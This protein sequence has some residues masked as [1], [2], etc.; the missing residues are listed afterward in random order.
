VRLVI[1]TLRETKLWRL[2]CACIAHWSIHGLVVAALARCVGGAGVGAEWIF[3]G[4]P[5]DE[6]E[7]IL[8]VFGAD[9]HDVL[10]GDVSRPVTFD[11]AKI[12]HERVAVSRE[13][14]ERPLR[15]I[16]INRARQ[17][18]GPI[19]AIEARSHEHWNFFL[20]GWVKA[21]GEVFGGADRIDS[22]LR[23]QCRIDLPG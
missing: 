16:G 3:V 18:N 23:A 8:R 9:E 4:G 21:D 14:H 19:V 7:V 11:A 1:D 2:F 20:D 12:E 17:M 6:K 15:A 5:T 10:S 22:E 13:K